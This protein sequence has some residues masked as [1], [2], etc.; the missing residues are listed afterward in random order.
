MPAQ[1]QK[2]ARSSS[3]S[4]STEHYEELPRKRR[5]RRSDAEIL[6]LEISR[7]QANSP[8]KQGS[9][10]SRGQGSQSLRNSQNS[11][12]AEIHQYKDPQFTNSRSLSRATENGSINRQRARY[13]DAH[14]PSSSIRSQQSL[15]KSAEKAERRQE[16]NASE[17]L[18]EDAP[19]HA[20]NEI[21]RGTNGNSR[22][23]D[24]AENEGFQRLKVVHRRVPK[25]HIKNKWNPLDSIA[26]DRISDLLHDVER[27]VVM[28]VHDDR[29]RSQASSAVQL[30]SRKLQRKLTKGLPFP[31]ATRVR[32][33]DDFDFEKILESN[34]ILETQLT[35]M[36][37]SIELLQAEIA[38]EEA[39]LESESSDLGQLEANAKNQAAESRRA[40]KKTH[41]LALPDISALKK[42]SNALSLSL[43]TTRPPMDNMDVRTTYT[44]QYSRL[45]SLYR[46]VTK[47]MI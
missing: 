45:I 3:Q 6:A 33:E 14:L 38:K 21:D 8:I 5:A 1:S 47:M 24:K 37:H 26:I 16:R 22:R 43:V 2:R 41:Y 39:L 17:R 42:E 29:K 25:D 35:P 40:A 32:R 28:R 10:L 7:M 19:H 34:R 30:V 20:S 36:I 46:T 18:Q 4:I 13:S 12:K 9:R 44:N 23:E 11:S 27:S 31:P 15:P